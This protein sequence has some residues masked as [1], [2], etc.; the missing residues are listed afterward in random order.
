MKKKTVEVVQSES[1]VSTKVMA[2]AI[3][4][5]GKAMKT[6]STSRLKE[7]TIVLL[8]SHKTRLPQYQV[9][10]VFDSLQSLE[11]DWLK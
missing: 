6:L 11:K 9:A 3:V 5:I 4:D 10:A 8:V 2:Q 7:D 1:P